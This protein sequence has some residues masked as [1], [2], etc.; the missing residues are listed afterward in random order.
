MTQKIKVFG[1]HGGNNGVSMYRTWQPLANLGPDFNVTMIPER[2][3]RVHWKDWE[4]PSNVPG[5]GSHSEIIENNDVIFSNFRANEDD[6]ARLTITSKLKKLVMDIDDDILHLPS[7]NQN[8][9]FWFNEENGKDVWSEIPEEEEKDEK[10]IKIAAEMQSQLIRH[11]QTGRLGF[12]QM[13][14][15]PYEMVLQELATAQLVTV[16]TDKMKEIYGRYNPNT[17]VIPNAIDFSKYHSLMTPMNDGIIRLGLFGSNSHYRDWKTIAK[18]LKSILDEFPNVHLCFNTWFR[19]KGA[20][21]S[22][23][24]EQ[25]LTLLF[26]DFFDGFREHPQCEVFSGVEIGDYHEWLQDK[27][28]DI[29]LAPLCNSEFNKA[30]SNIKYLEFGA[31][32]VPGV[33]QDMDPYNKDVKPG[34][35]GMLASDSAQWLKC[36][37]MLIT[38]AGLRQ[39]MGDLAYQDV[40]TRYDVKDVGR[41]L[42]NEIKKIMGQETEEI[43]TGTSQ[44]V[45]AR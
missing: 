14:R 13:R 18:V 17:V 15:H 6:C 21:G 7:D 39:K 1:Y 20:A 5:I 12:Y 3:E 25:E 29:G 22:S 26:P 23:M 9:K 30:K 41:K 43:K 34:Y 10:W 27:K 28:I 24:D 8:Y 38:N 19:A 42:G 32:R 40:K 4:T 33:F 44:L 36:L 2:A 35:N 37:R 45:L 31:M 11:P 16:S